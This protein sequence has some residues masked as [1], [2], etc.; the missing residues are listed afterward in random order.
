MDSLKRFFQIR[1]SYVKFLWSEER[2]GE[3]KKTVGGK[4]VKSKFLVDRIQ[5]GVE[6]GKGGDNFVEKGV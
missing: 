5:E 3:G 2:E 4:R 6:R 1:K